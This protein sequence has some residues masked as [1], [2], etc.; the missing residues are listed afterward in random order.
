MSAVSDQG[1]KEMSA[2][3]YTRRALAVATISQR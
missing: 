2:I 3:R 1:L